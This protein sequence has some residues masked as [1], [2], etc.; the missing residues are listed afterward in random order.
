MKIT[1]ALGTSIAL[2]VAFWVYVS[3]GLPELK[4]YPWIGFVAWAAFFAAG[5]GR[6]G[7]RGPASRPG[8][9]G[10]LVLS[11]AAQRADR[12]LAEAKHRAP[13]L[14]GRRRRQRYRAGDGSRADENRLRLRH[15]AARPAPAGLCR[16]LT[17]APPQRRDETGVPGT[18]QPLRQLHHP[19]SRP[20]S[21]PRAGGRRAAPA[22]A[23]AAAGGALVSR[24]PHSV[25]GRA[26]LL[27]PRHPAPAPGQ[28]AQPLPAGAAALPSTGHSLDPGGDPPRGQPQSPERPRT[29]PGRAPCARPAPA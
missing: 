17:Q 19:Q 24:W 16:A 8:I 2:L 9:G 11:R 28:A 21:L 12:P 26:G 5:G 29:G 4:L 14:R 27:P 22:A 10:R 3:I 25:A 18:A 15:G 7:P 6:A 1:H 13:N 20:R 23:P